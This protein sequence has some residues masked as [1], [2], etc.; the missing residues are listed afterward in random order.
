MQGTL[1]STTPTGAY[2][3]LMKDI[4]SGSALLQALRMHNLAFGNP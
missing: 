1:W 2:E 4:S 3:V